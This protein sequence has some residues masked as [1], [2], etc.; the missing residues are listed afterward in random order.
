MTA[1]EFFQEIGLGFIL[2]SADDTELDV[3]RKLENRSPMAP[4]L[5]DLESLY[6]IVDLTNR[7]TV[8]E[9]GCG[10]STLVLAAAMKKQHE[11]LGGLGSF[12]RNNPYQVWSLDDQKEFVDVAK[13]RIPL[14]LQEYVFFEVAPVQ[15]VEWNGRY[16]TQ[17]QR[18][19]LINP[20]FI[21]IDAPEQFQT[22]GELCG[23][24][25]RHKDLMP[26]S[27]DVLK[28]EHFLTPKTIIVVDGR[29][30]NARFIKSNLQRN[31]KYKYCETRDQ[32]FFL[33][34]EPPLGKYSN[35]M[36]SNIY[37]RDRTWCLD[38]L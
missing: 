15:M 6:R 36:I 28:I 18:L 4:V 8:L 32:H 22:S 9:F 38:D 30:A 11:K 2:A 16:A 29:G 23:W 5:D 34:E 26:M 37:F 12:R 19:P 21:Y 27:C 31:W 7:T 20:D 13:E 1:A 3:N 10:W 25:T 24:S 33:L 17:Y 14:N 35:A